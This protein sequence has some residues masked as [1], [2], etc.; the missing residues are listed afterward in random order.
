LAITAGQPEQDLRQ[1]LLC[2][3]ESEID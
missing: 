3:Q 1:L 2:L